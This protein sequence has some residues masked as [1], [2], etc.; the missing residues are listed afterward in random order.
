MCALEGL[1]VCRGIPRIFSMVDNPAGP[2]NSPVAAPLL[3]E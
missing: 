1:V 2:L 3:L